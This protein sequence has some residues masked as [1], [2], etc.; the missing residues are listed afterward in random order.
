[1]LRHLSIG[2]LASAVAFAP[3]PPNSQEDIT[4]R[5]CNVDA[6][7]IYKKANAPHDLEDANDTYSSK[8]IGSNELH[9]SFTM[10]SRY[11]VQ[12]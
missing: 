6:Q 1:M 7:E 2:L 8:C 10:L 11:N 4:G 12:L 5:H 9:A 3:L